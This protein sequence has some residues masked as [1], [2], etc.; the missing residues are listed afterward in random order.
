MR[1]GGGWQSSGE[2]AELLGVTP[3]TVHYYEEQGLV[4]PERTD[5]GTRFCSDFDV[6]RLEVCVRL[7]EL[8]VPIR[9]IARLAQIRKEAAT[10]EAT[11]RAL[12]EVFA[13]MRSTF[14]ERLARLRYVLGDLEKIERLVRGCWTCPNKPN[15]RDCPGERELN[16]AFILSLTWDPDR[17]DDE[18]E[19]GGSALRGAPGRSSTLPSARSTTELSAALNPDPVPKRFRSWR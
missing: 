7:A 11:S 17:P 9:T 8:G 5:E 14:R 4:T 12:V 6:R 1:R 19:S 16:S 3:R 2:V 13:G 10:G 18:L 15:P